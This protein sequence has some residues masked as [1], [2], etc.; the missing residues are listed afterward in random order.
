MDDRKYLDKARFVVSYRICVTVSEFFVS[1]VRIGQPESHMSQV[2]WSCKDGF[3]AKEDPE[4]ICWR[5][6]YQER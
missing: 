5:K 6:R 4:S 3:L 2:T 1:N